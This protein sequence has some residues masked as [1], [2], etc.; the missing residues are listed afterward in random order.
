M[1]TQGTRGGSAGWE[2]AKEGERMGEGARQ[3]GRVERGRG[4]VGSYFRELEAGNN[5]GE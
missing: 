1:W 5:G 3:G 4:L 2:D